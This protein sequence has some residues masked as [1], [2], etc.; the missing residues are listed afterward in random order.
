MC[1]VSARSALEIVMVAGPFLGAGMSISAVCKGNLLATVALVPSM[2]DLHPGGML[3]PSMD[4]VLPAM[5]CPQEF[6][7]FLS[8]LAS[9]V[10]DHVTAPASAPASASVSVSV[11]VCVDSDAP[12]QVLSAYP[13]LAA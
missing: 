11:S 5:G 2:S 13:D 7:A 8:N 12:V 1:V 6:A 4:D 9:P 3:P 10:V